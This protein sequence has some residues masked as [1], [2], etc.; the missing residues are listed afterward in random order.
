MDKT[1]KEFLKGLEAQFHDDRIDLET[2]KKLG[3]RML[4]D[5]FYRN[6]EDNVRFYTQQKKN[7]MLKPMLESINKQLEE[8]A[9]REQEMYDN[10]L[11]LQDSDESKSKLVELLQ[12]EEKNLERIELRIDAAKEHENQELIDELISEKAEIEKSIAFY[13]SKL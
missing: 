8:N 6:Q 1:T 5:P 3:E 7:E 4:T 10:I 9:R 12:I 11:E 13:E 2:G